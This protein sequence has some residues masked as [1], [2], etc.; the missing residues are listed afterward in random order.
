MS[1]AMK[2]WILLAL[3]VVGFALFQ[4]DRAAPEAAS[5]TASQVEQTEEGRTPLEIPAE[6][7]LAELKPMACDWTSCLRNCRGRRYCEGECVNNRCIC[8]NPELPGGVC[9]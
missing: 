7:T 8:I 4:A 5:V 9:R 2:S 3:V 1:H 6:L